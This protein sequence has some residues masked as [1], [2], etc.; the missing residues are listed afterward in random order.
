VSTPDG[1]HVRRVFSGVCVCLPVFPHGISKTDAAR[2]TKLDIEMFH[3]ESWEP[4]YFGVK[5][6]RVTRPLPACVV[7]LL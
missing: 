6:S 4:I 1:S 7:G 3:H 5:R 2:I